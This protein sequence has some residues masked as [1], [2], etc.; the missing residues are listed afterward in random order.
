MHF[1]RQFV[2]SSATTSVGQKSLGKPCLAAKITG[3]GCRGKLHDTILDWEHNLPENDLIMADYHSRQTT[4]LYNFVFSNKKS[5]SVA[6]LSICLGT[7]LQIVPSGKLPLL[8][9]K[10]A[11][12]LAIV[13]LQP[14]KLVRTFEINFLYVPNLLF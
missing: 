7:T 11:G 5:L 8:A 1:R 14:T 13:N 2:R 4:P 10:N 6:D 3:R 9:K 12:L